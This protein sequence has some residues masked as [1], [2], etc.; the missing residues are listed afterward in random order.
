MTF[1]YD[2][3]QAA[4]PSFVKA[5]PDAALRTWKGLSGTEL[6]SLLELAAEAL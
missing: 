5:F 2:V 6:N 1:R 3:V 4:T